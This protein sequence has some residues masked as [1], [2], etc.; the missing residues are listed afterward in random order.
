[1]FQTV[2]LPVVEVYHPRPL[3]AP[4]LEQNMADVTT[5]GKGTHGYDDKSS[6]A[7]IALGSAAA[8]KDCDARLKFRIF[9]DPPKD[10]QPALR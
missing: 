8:A 5:N 3:D 9:S 1:M 4:Y 7:W 2:L 10:L 6:A